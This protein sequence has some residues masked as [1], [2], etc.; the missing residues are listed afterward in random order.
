MLTGAHTGL[1]QGRYPDLTAAYFLMVMFIAA[2]ITLYELP[3]LRSGLLVTVI[4][5]SVVLYHP[6]ASMYLVLLLALVAVIGLPYLLY[7]GLRR[8]AGVLLL[9]LVAVAALSACYAA[10]IY[11]L[12][13]ILTGSS[14]TSAAVTSDLGTQSAPA[15]AH[16]LIAARA[17]DRVAGDLRDRR[18]GRWHQVS[19]HA[20]AGAGG[21]D[22][23]ADGAR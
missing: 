19:P 20:G 3:S 5:A 11:N 6:V 9:T 21:D 18:A 7:K 4:G 2:L 10:Y 17:R 13:E 16:L 8:D 15:A 22:G 12:G 14:A 23:A 1:T